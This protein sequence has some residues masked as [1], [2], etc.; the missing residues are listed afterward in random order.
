[1]AGHKQC[2]E[3]WG[4][5]PGQWD[6]EPHPWAV[7]VCGRDEDAALQGL[8]NTAPKKQKEKH[9]K[10][11]RGSVTALSSRG[12]LCPSGMCVIMGL[13]ETT[14]TYVVDVDSPGF[15]QSNHKFAGALRGRT[16]VVP[17]LAVPK[18]KLRLKISART[19][20]IGV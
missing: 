14:T 11:E 18:K 8:Y 17:F 5:R 3:M 4:P 15:R 6:G 19:A 20:F 1:M 12:S 2:F 7:G 16:W 13:Y 9:K 10:K